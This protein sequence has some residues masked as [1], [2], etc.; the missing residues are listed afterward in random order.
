MAALGQSVISEKIYAERSSQNKENLVSMRNWNSRPLHSAHKNQAQYLLCV[1]I[2]CVKWNNMAEFICYQYARLRRWWNFRWRVVP[3]THTRQLNGKEY[4]LIVW[5]V[6]GV[7]RLFRS[8]RSQSLLFLPVVYPKR[9]N[10]IHLD[11]FLTRTY[12][13]YPHRHTHAGSTGRH[14][15]SWISQ[16]RVINFPI[17]SASSINFLPNIWPEHAIGKQ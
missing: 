14:R 3:T 7:A 4:K 10:S 16:I 8:S 15:A 13:D 17:G 6:D 12:D 1:T 9:L 5:N 2:S 11:H